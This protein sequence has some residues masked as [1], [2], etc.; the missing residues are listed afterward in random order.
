MADVMDYRNLFNLTGRNALVVGGGS[1][2]GE[3]VCYGYA[4]FG[5]NVAVID[6]DFAAAEKVSVELKEKGVGSIAI[7]CDVRDSDS[8]RRAVEKAAT[9]YPTIDILFNSAGIGMRHSLEDMPNDFFDAVVK[10]NLYGVFYFC[11]EAGARMIQQGHGGRIINMASIS[12]H[13]GIP[14]TVNYCASK[15]GVVSFSRCLATEWACH[16]I[17]VNTISPS[18]IRTAMIQ[19][20]IEQDPSKEIFFKNNILLGRIGEVADIVGAAI[21][22][23]SDAGNFITGTSLIVD[24]GH[25]AR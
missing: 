22:L 20:V 25:S 15:G 21:F 10:T 17:N 3:G 4:D 7:Q 24:G 2:I 6:L 9:H 13:I 5:A 16:G 23:A 11:R 19:K 14:N 18:H 1:G 8:V 12:A